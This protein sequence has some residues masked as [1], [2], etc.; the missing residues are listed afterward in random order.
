MAERGGYRAPANPAPASG[1]GNSSQRTD[2][3]P[4]KP[5]PE[6]RGDGSYGDTK[7]LQEIQ[8]G[9]PTGPGPGGG[10]TPG[11][12]GAEQATPINANSARPDEP[13]TS[14]VNAGEGPGEDAL[15][16]DSMSQEDI[17][18]LLPSLEL[19]EWMASRPNAKPSTRAFVR[20]LKARL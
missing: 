2:G 9:A 8:S 4:A 5:R 3:G 16:L 13:V 14:G 19:F 17:Q 15:G 12:A 1:P 11:R 7:A 20:R 6:I 18:A 10:S